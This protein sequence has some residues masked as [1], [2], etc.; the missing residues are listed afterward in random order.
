M[1][2]ASFLLTCR[3]SNPTRRNAYPPLAC[4]VGIRS[5][6]SLGLRMNVSRVRMTAEDQA[7][8][9]DATVSLSLYAARARPHALS[10]HVIV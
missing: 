5:S 10:L 4:M 8:W 1:H 6:R 9:E 2:L 3:I 7:V